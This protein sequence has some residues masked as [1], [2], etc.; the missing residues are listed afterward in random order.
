MHIRCGPISLDQGGWWWSGASAYLN[1]GTVLRMT[2]V[3]SLV[4]IDPRPPL[5]VA[6]NKW[7]TS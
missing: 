3:T 6:R 1:K 4:A 2:G 5:V 7:I